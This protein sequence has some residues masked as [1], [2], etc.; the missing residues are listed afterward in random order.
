ML[1]NT[2]GEISSHQ[3][4][5]LRGIKFGDGL[6]ES[7]YCDSRGLRLWSL[8][9]QRLKR[10]LTLLG[11]NADVEKLKF[12]L[13]RTA[14]QISK[15]QPLR[16]RLTVFRAGTGLYAPERNDVSYLVEAVQ[17]TPRSA[18]KSYLVHPWL[19]LPCTPLSNMKTINALPYVLAARY[20]QT[21]G[22]DECFIKN[23]KG[24]IAEAVSGNVF[25]A[26]NGNFYTPSLSEGCIAGVMREYVIAKLAD[27]VSQTSLVLEDIANADAVW[28]TNA[29][30]G[31]ML[32]RKTHNNDSLKMSELQNLLTSDNSL[33][34]I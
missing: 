28:L 20:A 17:F 13:L 33:F 22:V 12:E 7:I 23:A 3:P 31:I 8:H 5:L 27:K 26:Q 14:N 25:I 11:L 2:N 21:C 34:E 24:N 1:F 18:P 4:Q 19:E 10:G 6:F 16:L 29:V 15:T 30:Q 9:V 32:L